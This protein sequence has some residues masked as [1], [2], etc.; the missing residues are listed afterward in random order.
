LKLET[1]RKKISKKRER[2]RV[3]SS[4]IWNWEYFLYLIKEGEKD[5]EGILGRKKKE[6]D[7]FW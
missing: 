4:K 1:S 6:R 2:M 5:L 7:G 3:R